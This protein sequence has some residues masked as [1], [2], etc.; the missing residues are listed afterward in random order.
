MKKR[1]KQNFNTDKISVY[2][3][4][5]YVAKKCASFCGGGAGYALTQVKEGK[6][7]ADLIITSDMPHHIIKELT[8]YG[9]SI[10][11]I[12]HY[13]A[14]E[15]GFKAFYEKLSQKF[16]GKADSFYFFDKRFF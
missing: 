5:G 15:Y 16:S 3:K 1:I 2:G 6:T 10:I 13:C 4:R 12:P 11:I 9:K 14:E 8:E 7:D